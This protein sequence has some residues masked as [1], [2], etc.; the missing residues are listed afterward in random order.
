MMLFI[1]I[2]LRVDGMSGGAT[3]MR[4][5]PTTFT[6]AAAQLLL[7]TPTLISANRRRAVLGVDTGSLGRVGHVRPLVKD[8]TRGAYQFADRTAK[9]F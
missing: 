1:R 3:P 6:L 7:C 4:R 5:C 9:P 8:E 2:F